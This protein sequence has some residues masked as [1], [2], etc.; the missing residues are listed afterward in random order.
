[1]RI[2]KGL[3][4]LKKYTVYDPG[5]DSFLAA[6]HLAKALEKMKGAVV[7]DMG[8][9]TGILGMVAATSQNV[10]SVTFADI[11]AH[12][13]ENVQDNAKLNKEKII[14]QTNFVNTDLFSKIKGKFDLIIF[15]SPYLRSGFFFH[16]EESKA[17]EGGK[18][19]IEVS[20]EFLRQAKKH[21]KKSSTILIIESSLGSIPDFVAES[22][23][24]GYSV[25][26]VASVKSLFERIFL[27]ALRLED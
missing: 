22:E 19:G 20:M 7:L 16:T 6:R 14:A 13:I 9:G 18:K 24:L 10:K 15:N 26:K 4:I 23:A 1:M 12:A 3:K 21:M 17:W 5:D 2:Y 8:T 11:N 25:R 27:F